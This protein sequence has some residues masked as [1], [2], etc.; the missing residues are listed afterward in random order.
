MSDVDYTFGNP[1]GP[2]R[3]D[4]GTGDQREDYRLSAIAVAVLELES[5]FPEESGQ[6][7]GSARTLSCRIR[8]LSA[9]GL[10]LVAPEAVT[11]GALLPARVALGQNP[12]SF[13]LTVEVV[14]C[15]TESEGLSLVGVE[16]QDSDDTSYVD[17]VEAVARVMTE[18]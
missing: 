9:K 17:W 6:V 3:G 8:D 4:D 1:N 13:E 5:G 7:R 11:V 14:W 2:K 16:I 18:D 15:R 12:E 10:C